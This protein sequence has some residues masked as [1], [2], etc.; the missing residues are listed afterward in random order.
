MREV[1][2]KTTRKLAKI[3]KTGNAKCWRDY[4]CLRTLVNSWWKYRLVQSILEGN[5]AVFDKSNYTVLWAS[6]GAPQKLPKIPSCKFMR[7]Y[8]W[9]IDHHVIIDC[10]GYSNVGRWNGRRGINTVEYYAVIGARWYKTDRSLKC[11]EWT[12]K[13]QDEIQSTICGYSL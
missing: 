11:S 5:P 8:I 4:E 7:D 1:Q 2:L 10:A 6:S 13:K 3:R 9:G 12:D